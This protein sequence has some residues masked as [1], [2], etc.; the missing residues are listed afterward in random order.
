MSFDVGNLFAST[1]LGDGHSCA[2][3]A[4]LHTTPIQ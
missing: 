2:W 1:I 4:R 3:V